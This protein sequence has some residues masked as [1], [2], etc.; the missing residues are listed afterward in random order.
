VTAVGLLAARAWRRRHADP[1]VSRR[2]RAVARARERFAA[3]ERGDGR[4]PLELARELRG[5]VLGLVADVVDRSE[6][7]LTAREAGELL[8]AAGADGAI[9]D[10]TRATLEQWEA[11]RFSGAAHDGDALRADARARIDALARELERCGALR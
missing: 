3:L 4:A 2:R 6:A 7:A 5:V 1:R 8:A 11:L 9:A 10:A